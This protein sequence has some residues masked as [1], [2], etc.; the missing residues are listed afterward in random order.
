M[1][2]EMDELLGREA[3]M[4]LTEEALGGQ[5]RRRRTVWRRVAALAA[6][7][8]L[9]VGIANRE[10]IA[11]GVERMFRYIAGVG[12]AEQAGAVRLLDEPVSVTR[13]GRTY[14]VSWACEQD[15]LVD[16]VVEVRSQRQEAGELC[17]VRAELWSGDQR[18]PAYEWSSSAGEESTWSM[19]PFVTP[20]GYEAEW[21][22]FGYALPA[23]LRELPA[24]AFHALTFGA[25]E[26]PYRLKVYADGVPGVTVMDVALPLTRDGR[27]ANMTER[28][29]AIPEGPVTALAAEDGRRLFLE[30]VPEVQR[31]L[32]MDLAFVDE[33][34]KRW[35][36]AIPPAMSWR[37]QSVELRPADEPTSPIVS[38]EI[39]GVYLS[40]DDGL[41]W[42]EYH[43]LNWT[44]EI[45]Q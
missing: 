32:P 43:G 24:M 1:R 21:G 6:C 36:A 8:A 20:E 4:D 25:G 15:G 45:S 11:T 7:A 34:G 33:S 19:T 39:G 29:F 12:P 16:L 30:T 23:D 31:L 26:G 44:I 5:R 14:R 13:S 41:T 40:M 35:P 17:M 42:T 9:V 38:I 2:Y 27:E 22:V 3:L 18:M 37:R 10:A 28:T